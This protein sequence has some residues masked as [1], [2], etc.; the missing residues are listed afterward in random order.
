MAGLSFIKNLFKPPSP[1]REYSIQIHGRGEDMTYRDQDI[2]LALERTYC[3]GHRLFCDNTQK[4]NNGNLLPLEKRIA[5]INN[6]CDYFKTKESASIFVLDSADKD[7][8]NLESYLASLAKT[9]HKVSIES[10]SAEI[11]EQ[12]QDDMYLSILSAGK[13]LS[14]NGHE[15]NSVEE[16]FLWKKNA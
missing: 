7:H 15:I 14:I 1:E 9:G 5:I 3:N 8:A 12:N 11:R 10:D 6:L 2:E 4:D 13:K 16:Y